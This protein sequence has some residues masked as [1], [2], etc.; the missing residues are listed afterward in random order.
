MSEAPL[1]PEPVVPAVP[2]VEPEPEGAPQV[3]T[4]EQVNAINARD[5]RADR[6]R[7]AAQEAELTT[8]REKAARLDALEAE[9]L[10]AVEKEK[11][12]ADAAEAA[13]AESTARVK[14]AE[15]QA[16]RVKVG[17]EKGL[18]SALVNRLTGEDEESIAADA[19]AI[20]ASIPAPGVPPAVH[21]VMAAD[22]AKTDPFIAGLRG[23]TP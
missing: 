20:L 3:F 11:A 12:R 19:D 17:S 7:I 9:Q 13:L 21:D 18:P 15:L 1:T 5:R 16:L 8:A 2:T 23:V 6:E 10:T 14:A 4:Q 22:P